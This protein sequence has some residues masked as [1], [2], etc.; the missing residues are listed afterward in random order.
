MV[1]IFLSSF[2][3]SQI[4]PRDRM[5]LLSLYSFTE[6]N[7]NKALKILEKFSPT[8][9]VVYRKKGESQAETIFVINCQLS[10]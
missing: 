8:Y 9:Q 7:R 10:K 5:I 6:E 3:I 2:L 1:Y 4:F